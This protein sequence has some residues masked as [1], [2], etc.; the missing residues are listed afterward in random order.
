MTTTTHAS[1]GSGQV[2]ALMVLLVLVL[3]LTIWLCTRPRPEGSV[4]MV[5]WLRT[6][7]EGWD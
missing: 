7:E 2:A 3:G 4:P 1:I 5:R 6:W